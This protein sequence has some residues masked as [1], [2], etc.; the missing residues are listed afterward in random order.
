M[1]GMAGAA[2][3]VLRKGRSTSSP[4]EDVEAEERPRNKI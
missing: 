3:G 2:Y 1:P 4:V